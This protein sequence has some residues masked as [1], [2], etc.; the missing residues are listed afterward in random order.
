[1]Y[2]RI[3][4]PTLF[5]KRADVLPTLFKYELHKSLNVLLFLEGGTWVN[6]MS[7]P[8]KNDAT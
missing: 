5:P 6:P 7:P 8:K 4:P 3:A 2:I 1:M